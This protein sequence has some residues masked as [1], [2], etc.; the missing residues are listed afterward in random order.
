MN[1]RP[2]LPS[3]KLKLV[4]LASLLSLGIATIAAVSASALVGRDFHAGRIIDD[5]VFY[6]KNSMGVDQ[7]QQFRNA[8]MPN[9][10]EWGTQ[11]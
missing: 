6:N 7:I 3:T 5:V 8:K 9:C 4:I 11:I 10:D 2:L 1:I